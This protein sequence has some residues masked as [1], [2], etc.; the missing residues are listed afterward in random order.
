[1]RKFS[2][3]RIRGVYIPNPVAFLLQCF[4]EGVDVGTLS[5]DSNGPLSVRII[6][7]DEERDTDA[8]T[9][10]EVRLRD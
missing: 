7:P 4:P 1:M 9:V 3:V 2:E 5:M 10:V 6:G 8:E